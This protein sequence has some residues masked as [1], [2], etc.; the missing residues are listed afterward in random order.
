MEDVEEYWRRL[1]LHY[2]V[3]QKWAP[4]LKPDLIHVKPPHDEL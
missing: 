2:S 3:L 1:L 4:E